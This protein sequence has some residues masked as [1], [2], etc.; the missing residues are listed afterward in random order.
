MYIGS[1]LSQNMSITISV[2]IIPGKGTTHLIVYAQLYTPDGEHHGLNGFLVQVRDRKTLLPLP[3]VTIGDLGEKIGL[4]GIDNGFVMFNKYRIIRESLLGKT[5]VV[6]ADGKFVSPIQD[7]KKRIGASFGSLSAGRVNICGI[8]NTYLTKAISIAV[9][10]SASRRQFGDGNDEADELPVL[11]YQSQQ[12]RVLPHLA[13][14][15]VQKVFTL[16]LVRTYTDIARRSFMG[17]NVGKA[18]LEMHAM[19]S[20]V[21]PVCTWAVRDAIQDC[22]EACGGHGYLKGNL[23]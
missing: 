21:K 1:F 11:E 23:S 14:C 8:S 3:G 6:T 15:I 2:F 13:T 17:E 5:G 10:Y 12:Y 16:W 20:A 9:R 4:N 7:K 18:S 22:R 19:S